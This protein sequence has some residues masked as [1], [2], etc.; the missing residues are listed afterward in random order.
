MA[1]YFGINENNVNSFFSNMTGGLGNGGSSFGLSGNLLSDYASIKSGSYHK[2]LKAYY[3]KVDPD[4]KGKT[5]KTNK[6]SANASKETK[7]LSKAQT[8]ADELKDAASSLVADKKGI[9]QLKEVEKKDEVTGEVST[10]KEYDRDAMYQAVKS[11]VDEYNDVLDS[12]DD[13]DSQSVL[14][15]GVSLL[16]TTQ[17][18]E[19][20]LSKAGI[21]IGKG[22][23]LE[24]D[25]EA[26][27]KADMNVVK[28]LFTGKG[29]YA[30]S[31]SSKSALISGYAKSATVRSI[32][33]YN[34]TGGYQSSLLTGNIYDS[35]F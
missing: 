1:S 6:V 9:F 2:L 13:V 25:K 28:T 29:S 32:G 27:Q 7:V 12:V 31:V 16:K 3:E 34:G 35:F 11:F 23:K 10:V 18:N 22:N 33:S 24:I 20:L 15:A 30:D 5:D 17:S 21:T 4:T 26:F 14:R 19:D 8:E